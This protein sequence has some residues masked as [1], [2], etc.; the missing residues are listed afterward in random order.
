MVMNILAIVA[1]AIIATIMCK[2][3][4]K[5]NKIYSVII[6]LAATSIILLVVFTY[7]SPIMS[8]ITGLFTRSGLSYQYTEILFKALGICY[9]TQ[10]AYDIC[11]DSNENAIDTQVELAG[12]VSL[13]ILSLPLFQSLIEIVTKLTSL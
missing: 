10:L 8:T 7:V 3:M 12:K 11:K 13:I 5:Y 2:L 6:T 1:L 4:D 9:I